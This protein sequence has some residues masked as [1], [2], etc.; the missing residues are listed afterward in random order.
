MNQGKIILDFT[1]HTKINRP[2]I[3][4]GDIKMVF[5]EKLAKGAESGKIDAK[6][7]FL[8]PAYLFNGVVKTSGLLAKSIFDQAVTGG[9]EI[10]KRASG[11]FKKNKN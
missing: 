1:I 2:E 4:F 9:S 10:M 3:G 11:V 6:G 8:L 7:V 5:Q